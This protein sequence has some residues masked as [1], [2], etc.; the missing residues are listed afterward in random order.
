MAAAAVCGTLMALPQIVE[1]LRI[2]PH[3]F[4]G[5]KGYAVGVAT[6]AS[7]NPLQAFEWLL[8]M[9]FGRIDVRA[10]GNFWGQRF[11]TG[12]PPFFPSLYPGLLALALAAAAGWP[13]GRLRRAAGWAWGAVAAG[14][15]CSLGRYNPAMEWLLAHAGSGALRYPVKFWLPVA[16]GAGLLCGIG[17]ARLLEPAPSPSS[18]AGTPAR[19][20]FF[21]TLGGLAAAIG[22]PWVILNALPGTAVRWLRL[23]I[24]AD[25]NLPFVANERLRWAG[26]CLFSLVILGL[27]ALAAWRLVRSP[28]A[29][30]TWAGLLLAVHAAAQVWLL[31]PLYPTDAVTPYRVPPPGLV[32]LPPE[33]TVVNPEFEHLFGPSRLG[34]GRFASADLWWLERRAFYEL[35]PFTGAMWGRRY[36]LAESPEG[37]DTYLTRMAQG[38]MRDASDEHRL[39]LLA[40]WGVGRLV[41]ERALAPQAAQVRL[42][43]KLPSF[44]QEVYFYELLNR[45]P[46]AYLARHV[47]YA[48]TMTTAY[49]MLQSPAFDPR[50]DAVLPGTGPKSVSAGGAARVTRRGPEALEVEVEVG[51]GG[52]VLVVQRAKLLY[53]AAIDGRPAE[54]LTANLHRNGVVV[55]AGHHVVR[56]W[57]DRTGFHRALAAA[58][59]GLAALPLLALGAGRWPRTAPVPVAVTTPAEPEQAAE[60]ADGPAGDAGRP[61]PA[62]PPSAPLAGDIPAAAPV[63]VAGANDADAGDDANDANDADDA[64][65]AADGAGW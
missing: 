58:A 30:W 5:F 53:R 48:S 7:W 4:R 41:I 26:L 59:V 52:S 38:G 62:S 33:E 18:P 31:Q 60:A 3:S 56:M 10:G 17:F 32:F 47:W 44:G 40:A 22:V 42:L 35:F 61:A 25:R 20:R 12:A 2:L 51:E 39:R 50:T 8:P 13:R 14:L 43:G 11:Y 1:F 54:V 9:L 49:R 16:M 46:E 65:G 37:L 19:R 36:E 6:I 45:A 29:A 27:L 23:L 28:R 15:F 34:S 63:P 24:P 64:G 55:P 21:W 57:V